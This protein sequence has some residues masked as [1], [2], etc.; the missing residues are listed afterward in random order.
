M[1][2]SMRSTTRRPPRIRSLLAGLVLALTGGCA[3]IHTETTIDAPPETVWEILVDAE[4]YPEWNPYH[5]R[6]EGALALGE[7]LELEIHKP[8]GNE[9][10]IHPEVQVLDEHRELTWGGGVPGLFTGRHVFRLEPTADGG[11]HLVHEET[12]R[13]LG[14]PFAELD[15]IE[16][17][18]GRVNEALRRRAEGQR[19][20]VATTAAGSGGG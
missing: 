8:N 5:V 2:W 13:G 7:E 9:V 11:T 3:H 16:E 18:Y 17:G 1:V 14:V 4:R 10:T 12:F 6:V 20:R 19:R 15:S